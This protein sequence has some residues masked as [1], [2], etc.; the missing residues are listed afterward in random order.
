MRVF[1]D[2]LC[3]YLLFHK[4]TRASQIF[5]CQPKRFDTVFAELMWNRLTA[6]AGFLSSETHPPLDCSGANQLCWTSVLP[7]P[8]WKLISSPCLFNQLG[9]MDT[10]Q[11]ESQATW[12]KD[13]EITYCPLDDNHK[14]RNFWITLRRG[15]SEYSY[16]KIPLKLVVC[17]SREMKTDPQLPSDKRGNWTWIYTRPH[18]YVNVWEKNAK[19][20]KNTK[21]TLLPRHLL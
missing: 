1:Q 13:N 7:H 19:E 5:C 18:C 20:K 4:T 3:W 14:M 12:E 21:K 2:R 15:K 17:I 9:N 8:A 11:T 10:E 6:S 16:L